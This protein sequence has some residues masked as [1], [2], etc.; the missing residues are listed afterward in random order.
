MGRGVVR[1][2]ARVY[3]CVC[4]WGGGGTSSMK[5]CTSDM[6]LRYVPSKP[7]EQ[8]QSTPHSLTTRFTTRGCRRAFSLSAQMRWMRNK[9]MRS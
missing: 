6:L 4:V 8:E 2:R 5:R 1:A 3:V 7:D 9:A